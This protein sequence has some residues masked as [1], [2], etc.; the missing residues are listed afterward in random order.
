MFIP[1]SDRLACI[2][3]QSHA[4]ILT[5]YIH[6]TEGNGTG[7]LK[8]SCVLI[9]YIYMEENCQTKQFVLLFSYISYG[10]YCNHVS[11]K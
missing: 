8:A 6:H 5:V 7:T 10:S 11:K 4:E 3:P 2:F 1:Q 9:L